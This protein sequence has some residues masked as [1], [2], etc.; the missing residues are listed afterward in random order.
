MNRDSRSRLF[1]MPAVLWMLLI[2]FFSAMPEKVSEEQSDYVSLKLQRIIF[3]TLSGDGEGALEE[4][5][6]LDEGMP[7]FSVRKAAHIFE[8]AVLCVFL[9]IGLAGRRRARIRSLVW[10]VV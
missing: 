2:F 8:Y 1:F 10:T 3:H 7:L 9:Y 4:W 5:E 6:E